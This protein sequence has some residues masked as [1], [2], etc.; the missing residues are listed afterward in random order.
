VV[1]E[2]ARVARR[3]GV[4]DCY[5]VVKLNER[6]RSLD[7]CNGIDSHGQVLEEQGACQDGTSATAI[8]SACRS[9]AT[10]SRLDSYFPFD[11]YLLK[12]SHCYIGDIYLS[13]KA[14]HLDLSD[15][16]EDDEDGNQQSPDPRH[17][18]ISVSQDKTW[19]AVARSQHSRD[20]TP[21]TISSQ[22]HTPASADI[23]NVS[24]SLSD[25]SVNELSGQSWE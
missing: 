18:A 13:Y 7:A 20:T 3:Y 9:P 10:S 19:R 1:K 14:T 5:P 11:P 23:N 16:D 6:L 22:D 4:V 24:V 2:F 15:D 25:M 21:D 17:K 12:L 8:Y